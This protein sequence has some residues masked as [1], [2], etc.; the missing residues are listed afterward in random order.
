MMT[1]V[2]IIIFF[3]TDLE[4]RYVI[5]PVMTSKK[6][7][8]KKK[9][10]HPFRTLNGFY[11]VVSLKFSSHFYFVMFRCLYILF[12]YFNTFKYINNYNIQINVSSGCILT[13]FVF[14]TTNVSQ[15]KTYFILCMEAC[16]IH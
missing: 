7:R 6:E 13:A 2:K 5:V 11:F 16:V 3:Y 4:N 8:Q 12:S 14:R 9:F 15:K 1:G 10:L